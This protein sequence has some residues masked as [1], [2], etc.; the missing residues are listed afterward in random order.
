MEFDEFFENCLENLTEVLQRDPT[1]QELADFLL[2][3]MRD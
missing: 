3:N 1:D 2:I